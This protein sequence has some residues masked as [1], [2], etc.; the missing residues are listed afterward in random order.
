MSRWS[1]SCV[2]RDAILRTVSTPASPR[3]VMVVSSDMLSRGKR[4]FAKQHQKDAF[5]DKPSFSPPHSESCAP[6]D[7]H[8]GEVVLYTISQ[9]TKRADVTVHEKWVHDYLLC[10][11]SRLL[12]VSC[13]RRS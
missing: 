2:R 5:S 4:Q 11:T 1:I 7:E 3:E 13:G 8:M 6:D 9:L 10:R 12:S